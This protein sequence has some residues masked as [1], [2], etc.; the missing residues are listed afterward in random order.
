[1]VALNRFGTDPLHERNRDVL[2]ADGLRVVTDPN[3]TLG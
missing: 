2:E 1:V 3:A